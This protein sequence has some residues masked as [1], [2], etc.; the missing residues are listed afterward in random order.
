MN[1]FIATLQNQRVSSIELAAMQER[2]GH[3]TAPSK[4]DAVRHRDCQKNNRQRGPVRRS[5]LERLCG[6]FKTGRRQASCPP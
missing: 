2:K 6:I 1:A 3:K 4:L 5:R